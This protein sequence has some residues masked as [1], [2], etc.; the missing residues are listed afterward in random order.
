MK[1]SLI[2]EVSKTVS[3]T[4]KVTNKFP[5]KYDKNDF[6]GLGIVAQW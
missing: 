3:L 5:V 1:C 4:H 2:L 6:M